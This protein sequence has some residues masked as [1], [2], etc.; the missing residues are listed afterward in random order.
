MRKKLNNLKRKS[1][2]FKYKYNNFK[3]RK[4]KRKGNR[5]TKIKN[6]YTIDSIYSINSIKFITFLMSSQCFH[7]TLTFKFILLFFMKNQK[8]RIC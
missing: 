1:L 4:I 5:K 3:S 6:K 8:I 7:S 2:Y